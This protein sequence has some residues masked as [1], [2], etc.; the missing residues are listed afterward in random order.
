MKSTITAEKAELTVIDNAIPDPHTLTHVSDIFSLLGDPGR[1]RILTALSL[2]E[3]NVSDIATVTHQSQSSVS[4][5]LRLL[6]AHNIVAASKRGREAFYSLQ[7][8]HVR[9]VLQ[10]TFAHVEQDIDHRSD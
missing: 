8:D 6:R 10:L 3:L 2:S 9:A 4:H 1:L 7:D 5:S